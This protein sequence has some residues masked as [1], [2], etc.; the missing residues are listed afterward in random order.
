M[1]YVQ[2]SNLGELDIERAVSMLGAHVK[3]TDNPIGLFGTGLKYAIAQAA[4]MN[5]PLVLTSGKNVYRLA[6]RPKEF[7]GQTFNQVVFAK[8]DG[9]VVHTPLTDRFGIEDWT[10]QWF[11]IREFVSNALDEGSLL[12]DCSVFTDQIEPV[13]DMTRVYIGATPKIREI[14]ENIDTYFCPQPDNTVQAGSGRCYKKGV[15]V[16]SLDLPIDVWHDDIK[17]TETRTMNV[18][19]ALRCAAR[20]VNDSEDVDVWSAI[21]SMSLSQKQ[22]VDINVYEY[23]ESRQ[24]AIKQALVRMFG[25]NYCFCPPVD[26]IVR[27]IQSIGYTPVIFPDNWYVDSEA[28]THYKSLMKVH[29]TRQP[30]TDEQRELDT[31]IDMLVQS[32][33]I[34][35]EL[36]DRVKF[37]IFDDKT[38][39]TGEADMYSAEILLSSKLFNEERNELL[40]TIIHEFGHII[41]RAGD[42]SRSFTNFFV[43]KLTEAVLREHG[44]K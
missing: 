28:Y 25:E 15:Y 1:T 31:I 5:I 24:Q 29:C 16:G 3:E 33:I 26:D 27:D 2:I 11:I 7:R 36:T 8:N 4:R 20:L 43:Q 35:A 23:P 39:I 37:L 34:P 42:Y 6:T 22:V 9:T 21:L 41:T 40:P 19:S 13:E 30:N 38:K 14:V 32:K 12:E 44:L 17:L 10:E 18:E